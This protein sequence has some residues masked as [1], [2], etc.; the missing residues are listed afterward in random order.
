MLPSR[1]PRKAKGPSTDL[2]E[3]S[4]SRADVRKSTHTA[5]A[6]RCHVPSRRDAEFAPTAALGRLGAQET[7][8]DV[9]QHYFK[10]ASHLVVHVLEPAR[11]MA[12]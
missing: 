2:S 7:A 12:P 10:R 11:V 4:T 9:K 8:F 5:L 6:A 1:S 3:T